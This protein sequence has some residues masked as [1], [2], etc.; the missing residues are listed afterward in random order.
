MSDNPTLSIGKSDAP[1]E[2]EGV[3]QDMV[4]VTWSA[5]MDDLYTTVIDTLPDGATVLRIVKVCDLPSGDSE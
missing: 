5:S 1:E 3:R 4:T 2:P